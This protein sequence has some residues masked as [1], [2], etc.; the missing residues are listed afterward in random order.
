MIRHN[1]CRSEDEP[2]STHIY[3]YLRSLTFQKQV[4][5]C[6]VASTV[7]FPSHVIYG[8]EALIKAHLMEAVAV[9]LL[10]V[11][12]LVSH[13]GVELFRVFLALVDLG[14]LVF[15]LQPLLPQRRLLPSDLG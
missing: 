3:I 10:T 15:Q 4:L 1:T 14:L 6:R 13:L 12:G 8:S 2:S 9:A 11:R 5:Y 7:Y